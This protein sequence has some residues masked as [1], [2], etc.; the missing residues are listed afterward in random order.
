MHRPQGGGDQP[1]S[2]RSRVKSGSGTA[3]PVAVTRWCTTLTTAV[4]TGRTGAR[5]HSAAAQPG[6]GGHCLGA[7]GATG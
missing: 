2:P 5:A 3:P 4:Y 6:S 7:S 1:Y